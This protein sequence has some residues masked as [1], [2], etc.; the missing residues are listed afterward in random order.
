MALTSDY[1]FAIFASCKLACF[2]LP[3]SGN[4][5]KGTAQERRRGDLRKKEG[6]Q[7][8]SPFLPLLSL[9]NSFFARILVICTQSLNE[10]RTPW[11][12]LVELY[13]TW[14]QTLYDLKSIYTVF[15][16][17]TIE[18]REEAQTE[19]TIIIAVKSVVLVS[20]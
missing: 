15:N 7:A 4:E 8:I 19:L 11:N 13:P 10:N 6:E 20:A 1:Y 5:R 3:V 2:S 14:V 12:K 16:Y 18:I 9:F 17:L